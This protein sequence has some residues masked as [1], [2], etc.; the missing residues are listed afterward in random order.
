MTETTTTEPDQVLVYVHDPMCSWCYGFAPTWNEL[1]SRLPEG[2]A[3]VSLLGGLAPDNDEPMP[4]EMV[5]YLKKTWHRIAD[6][7]GVSFDFTYWDQVPRPP[8]TTFIACRGVIA[9]EQ[10]AGQGE[11][12]TERLQKAY[13]QEARNVWDPFVLAELAE[14]MGF[15][16]EAFEEALQSDGVRAAH[17]EQRELVG[18][19]QIEGY[20]SLLLIKD[21]HAYPIAIRHGDA[22]TMAEDIA[23]LLAPHAD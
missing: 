9:A 7:C 3:V 10:V 1:K 4:E 11:A 22:A 13:Y 23:D 2:L 19:L 15:R 21:G 18:R 12:F 20:P 14:G 16:R 17:D 5:E 6:A 8:R